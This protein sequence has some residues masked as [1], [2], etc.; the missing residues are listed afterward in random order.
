LGLH[1]KQQGI[2][3]VKAKRNNKVESTHRNATKQK[4]DFEETICRDPYHNPCYKSHDHKGGYGIDDIDNRQVLHSKP[5]QKGGL[6][7]IIEQDAGS[8]DEK[9]KDGRP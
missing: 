3:E 7:K 1:E 4:K 5:L 6:G 8:A 9:K 2:E